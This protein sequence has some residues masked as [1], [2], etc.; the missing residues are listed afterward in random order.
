MM[1]RFSQDGTSPR[2]AS[3]PRL[4]RGRGYDDAAANSRSLARPTDTFTD[5]DGV[6]PRLSAYYDS[7][8]AENA[9]RAM[10]EV[11]EPKVSLF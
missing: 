4:P 7:G 8:G 1:S 10:M 11:E 3:T 9:Q 5:A 2:H 6:W